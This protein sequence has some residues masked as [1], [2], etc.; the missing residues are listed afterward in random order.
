MNLKLLLN[1]NLTRGLSL[2]VWCLRELKKMHIWSYYAGRVF[3]KN[4]EG[5]RK[6]D[7]LSMFSF[8]SEKKIKKLHNTCSYYNFINNKINTVS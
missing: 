2:G 1:H 5:T 7:R 8:V 4:G 6:I 3:K